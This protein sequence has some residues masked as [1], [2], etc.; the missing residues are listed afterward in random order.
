MARTPRLLTLAIGT[1]LIPAAWTLVKV[2]GLVS[3]RF[4]Q[5]PMAV[6]TAAWDIEPN[7][8]VH[9]AS[10]AA[11]LMV[12]F[13]HGTARGIGLGITASLSR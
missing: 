5:S 10:T 9:F 2:M 3:D 8:S 11:R 12:G 6:L 4:L 7:I 1:T 13:T